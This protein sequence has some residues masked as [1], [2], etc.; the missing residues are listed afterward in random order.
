MQSRTISAW[1]VS[2][3]TL[4]WCLLWALRISIS[5]PSLQ[6]PH[7]QWKDSK[8]ASPWSRDTE[9]K[10]T[11]QSLWHPTVPCPVSSSRWVDGMKLPAYIQTINS[12]H[13]DFSKPTLPAWDSVLG[14]KAWDDFPLQRVSQSEANQTLAQYSAFYFLYRN[15]WQNPHNL[16][17]NNTAL[18]PYAMHYC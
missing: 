10:V 7:T 3:Q 15:K 16:Q 13:V 4:F 11:Q 12:Q 17:M 9:K 2:T 18:S 14:Q 1:K 6:F 8:A 5:S